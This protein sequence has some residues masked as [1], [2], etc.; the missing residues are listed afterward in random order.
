VTEFERRADGSFFLE[1]YN[2]TSHLGR[3][4]VGSPV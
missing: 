1:R 2:D 3:S 4:H